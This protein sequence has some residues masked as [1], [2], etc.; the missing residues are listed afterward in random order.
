[1]VPNHKLRVLMVDDD[2][3]PSEELSSHLFRRGFNVSHATTGEDAV[4]VLRVYDPALVLL[5]NSASGM[6]AL[7]T[8]R[9]IKQIKPGVAVVVLSDHHDP[10]MIFQA[11]KLGA[12]DYVSKPFDAKQLDLRLERI[13]ANPRPTTPVSAPA[14]T[15]CPPTAPSPYSSPPVRRCKRSKTRSSKWRTPRR[16]C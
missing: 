1:M 13:L 7:D 3:G 6:M 14:L 15:P 4:R 5:D 10:E 12:D 8:L 9:R 2:A 11:S 16:K